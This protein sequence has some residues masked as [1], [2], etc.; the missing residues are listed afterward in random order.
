MCLLIIYNEDLALNNGMFLRFYGMS[1][2][3]G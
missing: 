3:Y 1:T 2:D